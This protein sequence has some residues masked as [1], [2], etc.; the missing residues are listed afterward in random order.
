MNTFR[1][2]LPTTA[3]DMRT[4]TTVEK[5]KKM[6][7]TWQKKLETNYERSKVRYDKASE[8]NRERSKS[9]ICYRDAMHR[10]EG[11]PIE[12][13]EKTYHGDRV[14]SFAGVKCYFD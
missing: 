14:V 5:G 9:D 7:P 8:H 10:R 1:E 3:K 6:K 12:Y 11:D 2:S 4:T 13:K